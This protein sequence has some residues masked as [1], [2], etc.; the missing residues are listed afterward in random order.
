[1]S[2]RFLRRN[3]TAPLIVGRA[4][5]VGDDSGFVHFLSREDG[6]AL[7]RVLTDGSPVIASPVLA[8]GTLVV[9]TRSGGILASS[10]SKCWTLFNETCFGPR[11]PP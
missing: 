10:L 9:V 7:T 11:R 3:L 2:E 6:S 5:V 8:G 4:V 1:V